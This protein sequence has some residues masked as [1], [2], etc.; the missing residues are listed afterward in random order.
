[1]S[2]R[3]TER[4]PTSVLGLVRSAPEGPV[5]PQHHTRR[6]TNKEARSCRSVSVGDGARWRRWCASALF[7]FCRYRRRQQPRAQRSIAQAAPAALAPGS[8]ECL[9]N[10]AAG[11]VR[12][13]SPFGYDASAGI[14]DVYAALKLGYFAD[15]CLKVD[16]VYVPVHRV[17]LLRSS[18]QGP[19]R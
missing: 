4:R 8:P 9:A 10:K 16:F 19:P 12:F 17:A 18:R 6:T 3:A 5:A 11:T 13:A 14:I 15:L 7:S 2:R 1:M